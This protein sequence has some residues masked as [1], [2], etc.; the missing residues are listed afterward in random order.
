MG[1]DEENC[2]GLYELHLAPLGFSMSLV[3]FSVALPE[4]IETSARDHLLRKDGQEDLCFALWRP[5]S[6]ASRTSALIQKLILPRDSERNVHGNVSFEPCY[7]ERGLA[8]AAATGAGLA[9]MH[10]HPKGHGWQD[11]SV[12]DIR[13][14]QGN[15]GAVYGATQLPF[16]GLTI[17]GKDAA[18]SARFWPRTAPRQ[19][20]RRDCGTVRVVGDR[21]S[22]TYMDKLAPPPLP[23]PSQI[24]TISSWGDLKQKDLAR[25]HVG[26][27]GAG[28]VGGFIAEAFARTGFEDVVVIDFDSIE[29]K[30]LDRLL[31]A[32]R[33]DIGQLKVEV[34][35]R[36][37]RESASAAHFSVDPVVAAVYEEEGFRRALDCDILLCCVDRPWGR[38]VLNLLAY[39]HLIPVVDGG[40]A[41]RRNRSGDIAKADWRA[42]T[43]TAGRECLECLGQ[44]SSA[45]VQTEREGLLDDP[46]YIENLRADHPLRAAEN[47]FAFSMACA[48]LQTLQMLSMILAPLDQPN[49]GAQLYHFVGGFME[50]P[51]FGKC[52]PNCVFPSIIAQGD[53]CHFNVTGQRP[54]RAIKTQEAPPEA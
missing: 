40:I 27:I 17:A 4:A 12:P 30:N 20:A 34:L 51:K 49:P 36:H 43:A 45:N 6:G 44:Y 38:Q 10:S 46:T 41:V 7:L 48:S 13:A 29:E 1:E 47:V 8:E 28:S 35:A 25:V 11:M 23:A 5:S 52:H 37:L 53:H 19:Y 2:S 22:I 18:W 9:L 26:L 21:L 39:A 50:P 31:Y 16:V 32:T 24:R 15:A 3:A 42:H 14:E 54:S 33:K